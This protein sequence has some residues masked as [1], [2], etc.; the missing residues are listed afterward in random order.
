[1][2]SAKLQSFKYS[3][4]DLKNKPCQIDKQVLL[5]RDKLRQN[6]ACILSMMYIIP[7]ILRQF[8]PRIGKLYQ[9]FMNICRITTIA[10]IPLTD[11]DTEGE[12]QV[13]VESFLTGYKKICRNTSFKPKHHFLLHL[14]KQIHLCGP[15]KHSSVLRMEAKHQQMKQCTWQNWCNLEYSIAHKHQKMLCY[16]IGEWE[17]SQF[18]LNV[19]EVKISDEFIFKDIYSGMNNWFLG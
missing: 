15:L 10:F 3:Y 12:L 9:L 2:I 8:T 17:T 4:L 5:N 16:E 6:A 19:D 11:E 18:L 1:M 7:I 14:V 13:Q